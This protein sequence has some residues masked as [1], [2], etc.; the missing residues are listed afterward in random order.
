MAKPKNTHQFIYNYK[1][2]KT[3]DSLE[4]DNVD[5]IPDK[6]INSFVNQINSIE[7][8]N[9]PESYIEIDYND[10]KGFDEI[11]EQIDNER[12]KTGRIKAT[13]NNPSSSR[14]IV[15]YEFE[16]LIDGTFVPF[17]VMDLP[18]KENIVKTFIDLDDDFDIYNDSSKD[19]LI[20]LLCIDPMYLPTLDSTF[21]HYIIDLV[22]NKHKAVFNNWLSNSKFMAINTKSEKLSANLVNKMKIINI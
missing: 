22:K 6:D 21:S 4:L 7:S 8:N 2:Q 3:G 20:E 1:F 15:L 14:S 5:E 19:N 16:I 10:F 18:G 9:I 12:K 13:V 11:V 17:I